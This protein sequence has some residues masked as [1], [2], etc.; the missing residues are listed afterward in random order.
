[1][2]TGFALITRRGSEAILTHTYQNTPTTV[3]ND[4]LAMH[5]GTAEL[6]LAEG[7][8]LSGIYYT[9]RGRLTYGTLELR[10]GRL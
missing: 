5:D 4:A 9:G 1:M 3:S 2:S 8:I 6:R 7:G 10:R